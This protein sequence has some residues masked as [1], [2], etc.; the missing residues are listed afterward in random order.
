MRLVVADTSPIRYLVQIGQIDLLPRLFEKIFLPAAVA[1]ELRH[2]SAPPAVRAWMSQIPG[3]VEVSPVT[4]IDDP[5]LQAL[6]PGEGSAIALALSLKADLIL[7]DDRKGPSPR[8]AKA[9]PL[10]ARSECS[11]L[12]QNA[13]CL[14]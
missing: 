8:G 9:L 13:A 12:P 3:W 10:P 5:V 11:I 7:I 6:D 1:E 14:T 2:P 4:D